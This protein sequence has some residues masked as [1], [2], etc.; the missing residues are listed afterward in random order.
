MLKGPS[1]LWAL[2]LALS[3]IPPDAVA[4]P[5]QSRPAVIREYEQSF[6]TYPFSDPDPIPSPGG[7]Y[8][9]FRFD[10]FSDKPEEKKWKVVE[11]EN[12]YL[13]VLILPEVGGKI[14]TAIEKSTNRP[15]IY[16][17][18]V[19]KFRDIAMRGPWTSGG[20]EANYGIIGHSPHCATPVDYLCVQNE[21]GSVSCFI[22][23]L[24]LLTR[25]RWRLEIQLPRDKAYF[26]TSS[27]WHNAT[28]L[29]QPY[30]TWMNAG[31]PAA[32][33][34]QFI[35]P[36]TCY[37]EHNG[38][39]HSWNRY[40]ADGRD[41]SYY[42]NNNFGGYKSYHVFGR[43]ADFF[44]AYWHEH[45]FGMARYAPR[46]EKLGKKIWIWGLSQQGM[47]WE[48]LLTDQDGQ[49]VELQS[50]RLFNQSEKN[51]T[52]TPFKHR[53]FA[54][55]AAD[56]WKEY[57]FPALATKGMLHA[58]PYGTLNAVRNGGVWTFLF[59]P[60]QFIQDTLSVYANGEL[61]FQQHVDLR[62]LRTLS[63]K[64][65]A[66]VGLDQIKVT[67]GR[68]KLVYSGH[69]QANV[70]ARPKTMPEDFDWN[71]VYGLYLQGKEQIRRRD[72][73]AAEEK[74]QACLK[75]DPNYAP[76]LIEKAVL[77]Y[78]RLQDAQ[79]LACVVQALRIDTY[80]PAANYFY[81]LIQARM[82]NL[83]DSRDGF[84]VA[85]QSLEY[86]S[87]AFTELAKLAL[88]AGQNVSADQH[89]VAALSFNQGNLDALQCRAVAARRQRQRATTEQALQRL[90]ELDPLNPFVPFERYLCSGA[91]AD[92][93]AFI[94]SIRNEMPGET[95]LEL[96]AWYHRQGCVQ[97]AE[98]V[99]NLAPP[100]PEGMYWLAYLRAHRG[101][102]TYREL[103]QAAD[104]A[105]PAWV[106]P[107]REETAGVLDWVISRDSH[108]LPK[109]YLAL[110]HWDRGNLQKARELFRRCGK[111]PG[112]DLFYACRAELFKGEQDGDF[113]AD[114]KHAMAL[115]P[116]QWRH[117][118][119]LTR[120]YRDSRQ[121]EQ[122]LATVTQAYE[123][124]PNNYILGM[125]MARSLCDTRQYERCLDLLKGLKILPYEGATDGR[126]LYREAGLKWAIQ[127]MAARAY[128]RSLQLID[129]AREWP[130]H[131]GA[132][133]PYAEDVDERLEDW[134]AAQCL[135]KM[136]KFKSAD[137]LLQRIVQ[138]NPKQ[139]NAVQLIAALAWQQMGN[140]CRAQAVFTDW[141]RRQ[142]GSRLAAACLDVFQGGAATL[143]EELADDDDA[144]I[145]QEWLANR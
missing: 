130:E 116:A 34:L 25:T 37:L 19:V 61:L 56:A 26:T 110:I 43:H 117:G 123:A 39:V 119:S 82:G 7:I 129:Q 33:N 14:W 76:A 38:E 8:P 83:I 124:F 114:M 81:G 59:C 22:G 11:L 90:A 55:Y 35:F 29:E 21:D 71:S 94:G 86:R 143:P 78:R 23:V 87:A 138:F 125:A 84:E 108:W 107:F 88:R 5:T 52:L 89:A 126:I 142:P 54:P 115:N 32:G 122:A 68:D 42:E 96:A 118:L 73:A 131:L 102:S 17:N 44:G 74:L 6:I 47:I 98:Q 20:I 133:K 24:D 53:G 70:L 85:G 27:F 111:S 112:S 51:S 60:I 95:F 100:S 120:F 9:Y 10:G 45:D 103:L 48:K 132:G 15:F 18:R 40:E 65:A 49:Y 79:A 92:A 63:V 72:Y 136:G 62:P 101:D 91:E 141:R 31:V 137:R 127:N 1:A 41:L 139:D 99:L 30:Y 75:Q 58:N 144:R 121:A 46:H 135:Y 140:P 50:G 3:P 16:Y 106:F 128:R 134:L 113:A 57:W 13:R 69:D 145:L 4:S 80:D 66:A 104:D 2:F 105:D 97:E 93:N 77:L 64:V 12:E 36:G 28:S 67:L 109:Y